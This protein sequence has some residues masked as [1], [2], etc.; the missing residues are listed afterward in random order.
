[1]NARGF[2]PALVVPVTLAI[3]IVAGLIAFFSSGI[4]RFVIIGIGLL[5]GGVWI[6]GTLQNDK[7]KFAFAF[8]LFAGAMIF[9]FGAG[10][11]QQALEGADYIQVPTIGYYECAA[12][13]APT[14]SA[15]KAISGGVANGVTCPTNTD[16]CDLIIT[17]SESSSLFSSRQL[18]YV[19]Y[20]STGAIEQKTVTV[21]SAI[22]T[23]NVAK[24]SSPIQAIVIPNVA[25]G[26]R[27]D[28]KYSKV[29][30][31]GGATP[32]DG[33]AYRAQF[34]PFI[35]WN[36]PG[37]GG[38]F[39]Y[40][41][42]DQG[43]NFLSADRGD[44]IIEDTL[45]KGPG[46]STSITTL[47]P[48]KTRNYLD[49]IV[50]VNVQSSRIQQYSGETVYCQNTQLHPIENIRALS[51][52]YNVVRFDTSVASVQCCNGDDK[53]G[54]QCVDN[55]WK[56]LP[57]PDEPI[58]EGNTVQCSALKPCANAFFAPNGEKEQIR[59]VCKSSM[60]VPETREVECNTNA[61]CGGSEP[62]C[63]TK[64]YTCVAA[65]LPIETGKNITDGTD[66]RAECEAKAEK[67]PFAGWTV[68][69]TTKTPTLVQKTLTVFT[70]GTVGD[71]NPT[72]E[73][74]CEAK[75][76]PYY[77]LGGFLFLSVI[78]IVWALRP[79]KGAKK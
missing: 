54:Y 11:M 14:V 31:L 9:I 58:T 66:A 64:T 4:L 55:K 26:Q 51:K 1:M 76:V 65:P 74:S 15:L 56:A 70:L 67:N 6:V 77:L 60:C 41:S 2:A 79:A 75:Y 18:S 62:V 40:T 30:L 43:C 3:V 33:A 52:E 69:E 13:S 72:T 45:G 39:E 5:A 7:L 53:P 61:A 36:N 57:K 19:R 35:L 50:P 46:T 28:I 34:R 20:G 38:R 47:E 44:L 25:K 29:G 16:Q 23:V 68:V 21:S 24:L 32:V 8:I 59:Y 10:F 37:L 27:V 42:V 22:S 78:V 48:Y 73:I 12:A 17:F 71:L 49:V 63:D